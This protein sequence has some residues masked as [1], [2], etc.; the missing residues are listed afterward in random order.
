MKT[1]WLTLT[2]IVAITAPVLAG[3]P[4]VSDREL[5]LEYQNVELQLQVIKLRAPML[6]KRRAELKAE[7]N[8]RFAAK[9][10]EKSGPKVPPN[11]TGE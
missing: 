2:F 8:K 5:A 11:E 4:K 1:F 7:I 10:K 9:A 6:L 3:G